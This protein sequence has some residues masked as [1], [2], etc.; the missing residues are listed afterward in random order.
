VCGRF[1]NGAAIGDYNSVSVSRHEKAADDRG[2]RGE[3]QPEHMG[4]EERG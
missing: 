4:P 3:P 1:K 2:A